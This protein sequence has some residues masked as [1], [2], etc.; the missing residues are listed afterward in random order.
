MMILQVL[1]GC[2]A[3]ALVQ[4][5]VGGPCIEAFIIGLGGL[6]GRTRLGV[7]ARHGVKK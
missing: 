7:R 1:K 4:K 6:G 3:G 5:L 2:Q